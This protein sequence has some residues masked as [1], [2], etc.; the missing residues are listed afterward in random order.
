LVFAPAELGRRRGAVEVVAT[1][2]GEP[3]SQLVPLDGRTT[4]PEITFSPT[5]AHEGRVTFVQGTGFAPG[6]LLLMAWSR[7]PV[8][9]P[10]A[11]PDDVGSFEIPVVM[12][13]GAGAGPRDLTVVMPGVSEAVE[14]PPLLVVQGSLQPPDFRTRN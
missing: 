12:I 3:V 1:V 10:I 13:R 11:V 8:G 6:R 5:V 2:D 7:G 9:L 4:T 14:A